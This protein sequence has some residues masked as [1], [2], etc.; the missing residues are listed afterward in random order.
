MPG[1]ELRRAINHWDRAIESHAANHPD[2][3]HA[4]CDL[5]DV[6]PAAF[7]S[8]DILLA[9]PECRT[10]STARGT[11]RRGAGQMSMFERRELSAA[12]VRSRV[13]MS[14]VV[15]WASVHRPQAIV[16]ENVVEVMHWNDE[17]G[18][19]PV[20]LREIGLLGYEYQLVFLNAMHTH[21]LTDE[22]VRFVT[23]QTRDRIYIVFWRRGNP[24]PDL[25]IF[26]LAWCEGCEGDVR[27]VQAWKNGRR[28][29][30]YRAQYVYR[31]PACTAVVEPYVYGALNVIDW[32]RPMQRVGDRDLAF[33]PATEAR[34]R[35]GLRRH[36]LRS[37]LVETGYS[38]APASRTRD[39]RGP[40]PAQT[41]RPSQMLVK[42]FIAPNRTNNQPDALDEPLAP[43]LTA[44]HHLLVTLRG[45]RDGTPTHE[46]LPTLVA[47]ASQTWLACYN[48]SITDAP[49]A[50]PMPAVTTVQRHLLASGQAYEA[51]RLG[52]DALPRTASGEIDISDLETRLLHSSELAPGTGYPAGY[53][54]VGTERERVRQIGHSNPPSVENLLVARVAASLHQTHAR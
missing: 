51:S 23:P 15:Q 34:L 46:P 11:K 5:I 30:K 39:V 33:K 25:A 2:V 53:V 50:A 28:A 18:S 26:P 29:G 54:L 35:A 20:W 10:H 6:H 14:A 27:S 44:Q 4:L 48:G 47:S 41:A 3:N 22:A 9:S 49:T 17:T 7:E 8:M 38:H 16:V 52:A 32:S 36:G 31:C 21:G 12:D 37:Y 40:L 1:V 43:V 45:T 13:T 24:R 19:F 42:G